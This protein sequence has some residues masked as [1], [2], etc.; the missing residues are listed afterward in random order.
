MLGVG[1]KIKGIHTISRPQ[2]YM[3]PQ[4]CLLVRCLVTVDFVLRFGGETVPRSPLPALLPRR[5]SYSTMVDP[6][7]LVVSVDISCPCRNSMDT[8]ATDSDMCV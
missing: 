6:F 8:A 7:L 4:N 1:S 3:V 5:H 2:Q